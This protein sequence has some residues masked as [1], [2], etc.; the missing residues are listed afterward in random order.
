MSYQKM[1]YV[2]DVLMEDAPYDDWMLF[3]EQM[4]K[5]YGSSVQTV[6][7]LGCG[8]GQL[9]RRLAKRGY[10]LLGVDY[11]SDML[12]YAQ[13]A[14]AEENLS[15]QWY[16]Q[17]LRQLEGF[18]QIDAAISFCDVIN[19]V[20]DKEDV[21][22]VFQRIHNVLKQGGL[23]LFD[24]HSMRHVEENLKGETFAEIYDDLTY[25][26]LCQPGE[27]EGEV[28]HEL[29]FFVQDNDRYERF[30]ET[31]HQ[32]TFSINEYKQWLKEAGFTVRGIYSDFSI[33]QTEA[34]TGE[35]IFFVCQKNQDS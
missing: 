26:W 18:H 11:S 7:D 34:N 25:V 16:K 21:K 17:D 30:D 28:Y 6:A 13:Q 24:A 33:E 5:Q 23:F 9:T 27:E 12:T 19:Y 1:A 2:Y 29:T 15:I 32:R 31:H 10:H 3:A 14:A 22:Q 35:R 4:F 20:T 8:T